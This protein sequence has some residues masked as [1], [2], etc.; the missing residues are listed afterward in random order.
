MAPY[1]PAIWEAVEEDDEGFIS[2]GG[3]R[4]FGLFGADVMVFE[5]AV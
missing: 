5:S 2:G 3:T 4:F 1:R